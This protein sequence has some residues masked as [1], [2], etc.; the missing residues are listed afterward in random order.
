MGQDQDDTIF[1]PLTTAQKKIFG[2][3]FLGMVRSIA[4][5]AKSADGS[6]RRRNSRSESCSASATGSAPA[7]RRI[8]RSGT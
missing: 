8:S 6:V 3:P 1:I 7:R 2:T 4:V 5:K